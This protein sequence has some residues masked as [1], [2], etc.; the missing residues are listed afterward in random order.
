MNKKDSALSEAV[1]VIWSALKEV[2]RLRLQ[3]ATCF[4]EER[5]KEIEYDLIRILAVLK[6]GDEWE[7]NLSR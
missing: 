2:Q 7:K 1:A 6:E 5:L 4:E 3:A